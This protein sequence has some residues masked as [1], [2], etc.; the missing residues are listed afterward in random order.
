LNYAVRKEN[1]FLTF[2]IE[3]EVGSYRFI[4]TTE[5][6]A[7]N[8]EEAIELFRYSNSSATKIREIEGYHN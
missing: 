8:E 2:Y 3:F 6:K 1:D 7:E 5:I 4:D